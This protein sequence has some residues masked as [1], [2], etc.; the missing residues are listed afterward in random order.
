ML[1]MLS[2]RDQIDLIKVKAII[3]DI[4]GVLTDGG[5]YYDS[6]GGISVK[7]N[8]RDG[9][10]IDYLRESKIILGA[11][12]GR[13]T[14]AVDRRISDLKFDFYRKGVAKKELALQEFIDIY[15]LERSEIVYLGDDLIDLS[16]FELVGF[17]VAPAD[18]RDYVK[19][20]ARYVTPSRGGEGAFRDLADLLLMLRRGNIENLRLRSTL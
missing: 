17:P 9:Q 2:E 15:G 5:L 7:F 4:D 6:N 20:K 3:T 16:V 1:S 12:T 11:I 14:P 10:I 18:A 8:V 19:K 13:N